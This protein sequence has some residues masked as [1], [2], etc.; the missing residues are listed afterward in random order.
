MNGFLGVTSGTLSACAGRGR[1]IGESISG[2]SGRAAEA[3][4]QASGPHGAWDFGSAL[5]TLAPLWRRQ[6]T[7]QGSAV[8]GDA[9]TLESSA[10]TYTAA[11]DANADLARSA[12][13]PEAAV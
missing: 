6:L 4:G 7:R 5:L 3:C 2:L 9:A 10:G 11:E 13:P 12:A 8:S 1:A